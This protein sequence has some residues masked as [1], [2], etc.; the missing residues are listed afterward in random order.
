MSGRRPPWMLSPVVKQV[1]H[2]GETQPKIG[3]CKRN[4]KSKQRFGLIYYTGRLGRHRVKIDRKT[5]KQSTRNPW[6]DSKPLVPGPETISHSHGDPPE[7][8]NVSDLR[9]FP[10]LLHHKCQ[11]REDSSESSEENC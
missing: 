10:V 4:L 3:V 9:T 6:T 7:K 5:P 8:K 11:T 2:A 1:T